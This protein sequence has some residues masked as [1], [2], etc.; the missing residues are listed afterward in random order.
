MLSKQDV[1]HMNMAG[2]EWQMRRGW[3]EDSDSCRGKQASKHSTGTGW[4]R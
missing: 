1:I 3:L 4:Q 2:L